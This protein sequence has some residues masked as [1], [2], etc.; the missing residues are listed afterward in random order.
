MKRAA[1]MRVTGFCP[2]G[3]CTQDPRLVKRLDIDRAAQNIV[4]YMLAFDAEFKKL[5][6]PVGNSS[7]PVGRSD[8]LVTKRPCGGRQIVD[9]LR[10]LGGGGG[11]V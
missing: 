2:T 7:L 10:V 8:A 3:I 6:A 5:M 4:E 11:Y 9:H 1:A